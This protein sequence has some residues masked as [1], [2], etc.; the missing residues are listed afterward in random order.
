MVLACAAPAGVVGTP[1]DPTADPGG[2]WPRRWF[3]Q[4]P[5]LARQHDRLEALL[6]SLIEQH[7]E[8]LAP[9][10]Q[11]EQ[12]ACRRLLW[13]LRLHLRLEERWLGA[14]GVATRTR[15]GLR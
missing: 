1:T 10:E 14:A 7:L 2:G 6:A 15:R 4:D 12:L 9:S 3:L 5:L 13:D 11:A 8:P